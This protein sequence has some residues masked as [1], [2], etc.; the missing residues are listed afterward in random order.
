M[1]PAATLPTWISSVTD[2]VTNPDGLT[3]FI[4]LILFLLVFTCFECWGLLKELRETQ[5]ATETHAERKAE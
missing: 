2:H 1:T 3:L 4:L 5:V